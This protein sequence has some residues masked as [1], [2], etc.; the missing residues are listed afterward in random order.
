MVIFT[1]M[2]GGMNYRE[3]DIKKAMVVSCTNFVRFTF[4]SSAHHHLGKFAVAF[5]GIPTTYITTT[6]HQH[7]TDSPNVSPSLTTPKP[8]PHQSAHQT[9]TVVGAIL[10]VVLLIIGILLVSIVIYRRSKFRRKSTRKDTTV[11]QSS[12]GN[13]ADECAREVRYDVSSGDQLTFTEQQEHHNRK[14]ETGKAVDQEH[15]HNAMRNGQRKEYGTVDNP[16]YEPADIVRS[17]DVYTEIDDPPS[18]G[19]SVKTSNTLEGDA[20][21]NGNHEGTVDN[22]V[23]ES[24]ERDN[25][26]H[27]YSTIDD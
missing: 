20:N 7:N 16:A 14:D 5:Q 17:D 2:Y 19:V 22:M 23:Y 10:G 12:E 8:R 13:G 15:G 11:N 21:S 27:G 9:G 4:A 26:V 18:H 24:S 6:D 3:L 25:D 1:E